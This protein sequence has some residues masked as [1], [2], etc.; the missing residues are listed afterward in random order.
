MNR[1]NQVGKLKKKDGGILVPVLTFVMVIAVFAAGISSIGS[2]TEKRQKESLENA[3]TRCI[4]ECYAEEGHYPE[5]VFYLQKHY[6]L[7]YNERRF[8]VEYVTGGANMRPEFTV[9]D[10]GEGS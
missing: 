8:Y 6:G 9:I 7:Q 10:R 1:F 2:G 5:D 3:L 4:T